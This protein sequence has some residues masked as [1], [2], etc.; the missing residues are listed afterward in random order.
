MH[1]QADAQRDKA[2]QAYYELH[3][4]REKKEIL[5]EPLY[6]GATLTV[7]E[8]LLGLLEI[9]LFHN[10]SHEALDA[11]LRM[12]RRSH[13]APNFVPG[14]RASFR[15]LVSFLLT[16][17]KFYVTCAKSCRP[18]DPSATTCTDC[19]QPL[20]VKDDQGKDR[21]CGLFFVR[22]PLAWID[23]LRKPEHPLAKCLAYARNRP[24][25][26]DG[27]IDDWWAC[28]RAA[29]HQKPAGA[30]PPPPLPPPLL[31][32]LVSL[33]SSPPPSS[34][35]SRPS[36]SLEG[37]HRGHPVL[38]RLAGVQEI[39]RHPQHLD[40]LHGRD[41]FSS[42]APLSTRAHV[43]RFRPYGRADQSESVRRSR[44]RLPGEGLPV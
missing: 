41:E 8:W 2:L 33:R 1:A 25:P 30:F 17:T 29:Q 36:R 12:A 40:R 15:E 7:R 38:G 13:P 14:S 6:K 10:T 9:Q 32:I 35:R 26:A 24:K 18:Y 28:C 37:R 43:H 42:G 19:H 22:D 34:R 39:Q 21:P 23:Q 44:Y 11:Q 5:D 3:P 16:D 31:S 27:I 20:R 4:G